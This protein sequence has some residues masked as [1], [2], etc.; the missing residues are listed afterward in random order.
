MSLMHSS[1]F[2]NDYNGS[3]CVMFKYLFTKLLGWD[4]FG[5]FGGRLLEH[6]WK[7]FLRGRFGRCF[8]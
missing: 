7:V 4:M 3:S 2:Q 5:N 8:C 6:V 1:D